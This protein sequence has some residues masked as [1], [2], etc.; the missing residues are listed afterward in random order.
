MLKIK[1]MQNLL[2]ISLLPF[3]AFAGNFIGNT[4]EAAIDK[5]AIGDDSNWNKEKSPLWVK[6]EINAIPE[7]LRCAIVEN[8]IDDVCQKM[9]KTKCLPAVFLAQ[10][11]ANGQLRYNKKYTQFC[12]F[13][14][15]PENESAMSIN[16]KNRP[17]STE[18]IARLLNIEKPNEINFEEIEKYFYRYQLPLLPECLIKQWKSNRF[19]CF[20]TPEEIQ[21]LSN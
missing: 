8:N 9:P 10:A 12:Y 13:K 3:F 6:E 19:K 14:N 17:P 21:L 4:L 15:T 1:T 18:V 7:A 5:W 2:C 11:I 20:F 16:R